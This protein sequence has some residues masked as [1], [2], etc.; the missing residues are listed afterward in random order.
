MMTFRFAKCA[1]AVGAIG[2]AAVLPSNAQAADATATATATIATA[3]G[4]ANTVDMDFGSISPGGTTGTVILA[5]DGSRTTSGGTS[6]LSGGPGAAASFD[7]TGANNATYSITLPGS[8]SLTG[9]GPAMTANAFT[10]SPTPTGTL[11]GGGTETLLIGATLAVDTTGNQTAGVYT[12]AA[13]T[14]TVNYN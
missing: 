8:V 9:P 2:L 3:I 14:V 7:V 4:L 12:S 5:T 13:F 10:S 1:V 6:V 11:S